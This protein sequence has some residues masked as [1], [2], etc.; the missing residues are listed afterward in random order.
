M[1][2]VCRIELGVLGSRMASFQ[3]GHVKWNLNQDWIGEVSQSNENWPCC[4]KR[5]GLTWPEKSM[6]KTPSLEKLHCLTAMER[7]AALSL[8]QGV[9]KNFCEAQSCLQ[10]SSGWVFTGFDTQSSRIK[11]HNVRE[12]NAAL[13]TFGSA[14]KVPCLFQILRWNMLKNLYTYWRFYKLHSEILRCHSEMSL[15]MLCW[16]ATEDPFSGFE[17]PKSISG[18]RNVQIKNKSLLETLNWQ[19]TNGT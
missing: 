9:Q 15:R 18:F 5:P 10:S 17:V 7:H 19:P 14:L 16:L 1:H 4:K 2:S 3:H 12:F 6:T 11:L 8:H 13:G